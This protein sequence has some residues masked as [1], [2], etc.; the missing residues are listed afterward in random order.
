MHGS[1]SRPFCVGGQMSQ[2]AAVILAAGQGKRMRSS[3]PKVL[4]RLAGQPMVR[5]VVSAIQAAGVDRIVVVVGHGAEQVEAALNSG[6]ETVRQPKLRGTADA[7]MR[8]GE[9]LRGDDCRQDI[10]IAYGDCPLLTGELF[11]ELIRRRRET[12]AMIAL[13]ASPTDNPHGY[14]R[15]IRDH[16]GRVT[17][18]V[19]EKGATESQRA[20]QEINAGVYCIQ[21]SWLWERLPSIKPSSTG[22][23]YLT[24]LVGL[25]VQDG[26]LVHAVEAPI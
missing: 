12:G 3:I 18:I 10:V 11:E 20:V 22:E 25:A 2:T 4:H 9:V 23:F 16:D 5:F 17:G 19:E 14:G 15:V 24:D 26:H 7:V 13:V 8:A 6:V 1:E 21:A